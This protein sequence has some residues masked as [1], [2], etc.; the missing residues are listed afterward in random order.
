MSV[1]TAE[2]TEETITKTV[3]LP[4]ET[5]RTKN[6]RVRAVI[7]EWQEIAGRMADL[8][9]SVGPAH[10]QA[11]DSTLFHLVNKEFPDHGLRKHDAYQAAYKVGEAFG[12]WHSNGHR[13]DRPT[14]G[15]GD[16][17]R[18]CHCGVEIAEND[19]GYGVKIGLEPYKPEWW[20]VPDYPYIKDHLSDVVEGGLSTG[21]AELHL[22]GDGSL[23]CNVSVKRD[24]QVY[25]PGE[26]ERVLGVDLGERTMYASAVVDR[27]GGVDTVEIR[28]GGEFRHN[29]ERLK[30]KR[31]ALM[32]D[33]DLRGVRECRDEHR[34]YT[35]HMTHVASREIVDMAVDH[36]PVTIVLE[37]LSGYRESA[38]DPIHDWPYAELQTKI[39]YK[40]TEAGIPVAMVDPAGSS[41]T[42]S[43]CGSENPQWRQGVDFR[44]GDCRYEV[45]ADVNAAKESRGTL[46]AQR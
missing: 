40:A 2:T 3:V 35:D 45:H 22:S 38:S 5:S 16:Y 4:L 33:G 11:Q 29:R 18:F 20:H 26:T 32:S 44:C 8:M 37:D 43:E 21:S 42:C 15:D 23:T 30:R 17:A 13:K 12:S 7:D 28:R 41:F 36:K 31:A 24:V 27:T 39:A 34:R 14:F 19:T 25:V 1:T 10:W 9:P 46:L 6:K